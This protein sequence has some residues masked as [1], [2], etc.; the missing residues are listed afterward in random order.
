[1]CIRDR[2]KCLHD[3]DEPKPSLP[4]EATII[5]ELIREYLAFQKWEHTRSVLAQ[6]SGSEERSIAESHKGRELLARDLNLSTERE[7][8][9]LSQLVQQARHRK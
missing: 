4:H 2:F 3:P 1:M 9:L 5:N 8:P 7:V 6:E